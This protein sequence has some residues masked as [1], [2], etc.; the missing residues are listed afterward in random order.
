[1]WHRSPLSYHLFSE[2]T[3]CH[4]KAAHSAI[5]VL[6]DSLTLETVAI[7]SRYEMKK[8]T[9]QKQRM[10]AENTPCSIDSFSCDAA[11]VCDVVVHRCYLSLS[12]FSAA[13]LRLQLLMLNFGHLDEIRSRRVAVLMAQAHGSILLLQ[14]FLFQRDS[15]F[16]TIQCW[17]S[18]FFFLF[19]L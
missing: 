5:S 19:F 10:I 14:R 11:N 2:K 13:Y 15:L 1:M 8:K 4:T 17:L 18:L 7:F 6:C 3:T 16:T 9:K 12:K